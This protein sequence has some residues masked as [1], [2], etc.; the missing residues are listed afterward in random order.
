MRRLPREVNLYTNETYER[1]LRFWYHGCD[2]HK[3]T[4]MVW[5]P[6]A[7]EWLHQIAR[8]F[9]LDSHVVMAACAALSP[10]CSWDQN[11]TGLL[12]VLLYGPDGK[13]VTYPKN[14]EKALR[15][16]A[17]SDIEL[18]L[19]KPTSLK[20]WHFYHCFVDPTTDEWCAND[21]HQAYVF[22]IEPEISKDGSKDWSIG[23]TQYR[24]MVD[25]THDC[26]SMV[27]Y[28][29]KKVPMSA[30]QAATWE[31]ARARKGVA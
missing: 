22:G 7:A 30:F 20:T 12:N 3:D 26:A 6:N 31:E 28:R 27:R 21:R 24:Q 16:L 14:K 10:G 8:Q 18:E 1:V 4:G 25:V 11:K 13:V 5:Y 23:I 9:H 17:G 29:G 15:L 2:G 19:N